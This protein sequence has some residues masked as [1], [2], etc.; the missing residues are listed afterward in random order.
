MTLFCLQAAPYKVKYIFCNM[1]IQPILIL[2]LL[3]SCV[4][5]VHIIDKM[6]SYS[7]YP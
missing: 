2:L 5:S 6:A 4:C 7:Q 1:K 3:L